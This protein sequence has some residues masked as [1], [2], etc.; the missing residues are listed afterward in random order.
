MQMMDGHMMTPWGWIFMLIF[1]VLVIA[2]LIYGVRWLAGRNRPGEGDGGGKAP[3][4]ILKER[5]ARGEI[6]REEFEQMKKDLE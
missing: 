3:I 2:A 1:W 4:E 5:Y 6:T